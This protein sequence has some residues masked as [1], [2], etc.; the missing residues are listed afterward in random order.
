MDIIPCLSYIKLIQVK[1]FACDISHHLPITFQLGSIST[2]GGRTEEQGTG[3]RKAGKIGNQ[4]GDDRD[5]A[6]P[7]R[8]EWP[9]ARLQHVFEVNV[10][11]DISLHSVNATCPPNVMVLIHTQDVDK[12]L[13]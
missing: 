10:R 11:T 9:A 5:R 7:T 1:R 2:R 3:G 6:H 8:F 12:S 4:E 13:L